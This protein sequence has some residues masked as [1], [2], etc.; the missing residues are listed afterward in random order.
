[1]RKSRKVLTGS[2]MIKIDVDQRMQLAKQLDVKGVPTLVLLDRLGN[3]SQL[4]GGVT[5]MQ[6]TQW[7]DDKFNEI[8]K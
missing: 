5:A 3:K 6:I 2:K 4:I 1:M 8:A 7:L